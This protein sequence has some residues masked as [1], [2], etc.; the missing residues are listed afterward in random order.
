MN[1]GWPCT[2]ENE[3]ICDITLFVLGIPEGMAYYWPLTLVSLMGVAMI[4]RGIYMMTG[5]KRRG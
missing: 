1:W 2:V 3:R 4:V 5:R